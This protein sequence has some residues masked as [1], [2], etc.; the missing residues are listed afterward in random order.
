[1]A[2]AGIDYRNVRPGPWIDMPLYEQDPDDYFGK[3]PYSGPHCPDCGKPMRWVSGP[4]CRHGNLLVDAG[5]INGRPDHT[6]VSWE[7][8]GDGWQHSVTGCRVRPSTKFPDEW[9]MV[10]PTS[11]KRK[12]YS[13][14]GHHADP[15]ELMERHDRATGY[16]LKTAEVVQRQAPIAG[17][18]LPGHQ[19]VSVWRGQPVHGIVTALDAST[20]KVWVRY[21]D[22]Q[23]LPENP[24]DIQLR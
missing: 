2:G 3:R 13:I 23:H 5:W 10:A 14:I 11:S 21:H 15:H 20:N 8:T 22:G 19:V 4:T 17:G 18:F 16:A 12:P 7:E 6:D 24:G 9:E 1:M